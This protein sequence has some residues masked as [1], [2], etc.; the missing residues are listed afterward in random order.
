MI[1]NDD[2]K[3][4]DIKKLYEE[5]IKKDEQKFQE[6]QNILVKEDRKSDIQKRYT[7]ALENVSAKYLFGIEGFNNTP[8][9]FFNDL[10]LCDHQCD[11]TKCF[12][13]DIKNSITYIKG[14]PVSNPRTYKAINKN[15]MFEGYITMYNIALLGKDAEQFCKT[16]IINP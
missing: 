12:S 6:Q 14:K 10:T 4:E 3:A 2:D 11:K 13:I 8:K 9:L 7:K 15:M 16:L 5:Y 1:E